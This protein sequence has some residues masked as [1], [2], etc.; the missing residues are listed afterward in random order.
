MKRP[1][2]ATGACGE[3]ACAAAGPQAPPRPGQQTL[4][5]HPDIG[6]GEAIHRLVHEAGT[7]EPNSLYAYM[8]VATHFADTSIIAEIPDGRLAG[9]VAAYRVPP[10]PSA[11]F[12][13]QVATAPHARRRG[14]GLRMLERVAADHARNGGQF[15]EATV[16]PGNNASGALF[17]GLARRLGCPCREEPFLQQRHFGAHDHDEEPLY[18]IGP[19]RA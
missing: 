2:T 11:I 17:H 14:L 19:F 16:A 13:W 9:F 1:T 15:L 18:R 10:R 5:R 4:L 7:L 6:D 3:D 8:L 12:V